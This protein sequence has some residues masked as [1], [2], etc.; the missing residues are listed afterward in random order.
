ME[1]NYIQLMSHT[2]TDRQN[3]LYQEQRID[4][5]HIIRWRHHR[6]KAP[7]QLKGEGRGRPVGKVRE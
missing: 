1:N 7:L 4:I 6:E 5:T 2:F 3:W